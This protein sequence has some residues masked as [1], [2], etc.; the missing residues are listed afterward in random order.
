MAHFPIDEPPRLRLPLIPDSPAGPNRDVQRRY[1]TTTDP[2]AT[3]QAS[4][5]L[6]AQV[7]HQLELRIQQELEVLVERVLTCAPTL[8]SVLRLIEEPEREA[9]RD[10]RWDEHAFG[11]D[12][13]TTVIAVLELGTEEE[14][15]GRF[16]RPEKT[17]T[18]ITC[19]LLH[20]SSP[21]YQP[22]SSF[23]THSSAPPPIQ[24][25]SVPYYPLSHLLPATALTHLHSRLSL[26]L[27][28]PPTPTQTRTTYALL[29]QP[30]L[31][32]PEGVDTIPLFIALFRLRMWRADAGGWV[33]K[34]EKREK[35]EKS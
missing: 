22:S 4:P 28:A 13:A 35:E 1:R 18:T 14:E 7:Q 23:P 20:P 9:M 6:P 25:R 19:P 2:G 26:L 5:L 11:G 10:G 8:P 17:S 30:S 27:P 24:P 3:V 29:S 21:N 34:R 12:P 32:G 16:L 31:L 33:V 15:V